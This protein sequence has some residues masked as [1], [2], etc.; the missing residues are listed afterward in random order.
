MPF[1]ELNAP[2]GEKGEKYSYEDA[3]ELIV[4]NFSSF[5]SKLADF[6]DRAFDNK[7]IDSEPREGKSGGGFC[8]SLHGI[9][10]SRILSNFTGDFSGVYTLAHEL[11][12]AYHFE[13]LKE[14]SILNCE[15]TIPIAETASIFCETIVNNGMLNT[16][17]KDEI[18]SI[19]NKTVNRE[20]QTIVD[21]Y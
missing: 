9:K 5:S 13:C 10:E 15:F 21:I 14:E 17:S 1:Y 2:I 16:A 3:R 7:W 20:V 12:H 8:C 19:L 6:A 18:I 11:G 4:K